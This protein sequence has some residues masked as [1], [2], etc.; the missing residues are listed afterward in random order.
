MDRL[1][2]KDVGIAGGQR[3][4]NALAGAV[5][6]Q[7]MLVFYGIRQETWLEHSGVIE[8]IVKCR[9]RR[10]NPEHLTSPVTTAWTRLNNRLQRTDM[11]VQD[12]EPDPG[13]SFIA[14]VRMRQR[15]SQESRKP[16]PRPPSSAARR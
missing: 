12:S 5:D 8:K 1:V 4:R 6:K 15:L 7:A 9:H 13:E 10:L 14:T 3:A 16:P 2:L 11:T